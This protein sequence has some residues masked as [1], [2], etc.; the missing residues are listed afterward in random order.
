MMKKRVKQL[1]KW[2]V[3]KIDGKIKEKENETLMNEC[4]T[5]ITTTK[6][7]LKKIS[8]SLAHFTGRKEMDCVIFIIRMRSFTSRSLPS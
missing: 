6:N 4:S 5:K 2:Q 7:L 3:A 8:V 1:T